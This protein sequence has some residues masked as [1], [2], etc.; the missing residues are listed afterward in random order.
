[1]NKVFIAL[2]ILVVFIQFLSMLDL[3]SL[4]RVHFC[5]DLRQQVSLGLFFYQRDV[6]LLVGSLMDLP[7]SLLQQVNCYQVLRIKLK[8]RWLFFLDSILLSGKFI[9][10]KHNFSIKL[11]HESLNQFF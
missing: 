2:P 1:M 6:E 4:E 11:G 10:K 5:L 3:S 8:I 9:C 7:L